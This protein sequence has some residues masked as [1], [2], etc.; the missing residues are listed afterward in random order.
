MA[1][2]L[3]ERWVPGDRQFEFVPLRSADRQGRSLR[4]HIEG[5]RKSD[6]GHAT[7]SGTVRTGCDAAT[8]NSGP[9]GRRSRRTGQYQ[10][11]T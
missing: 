9:R 7:V 11:S 8:A 1:R 10:S 5:L 2:T 6:D 3:A 4:R